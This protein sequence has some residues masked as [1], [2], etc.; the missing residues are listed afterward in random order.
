M[1]STRSTT[2]PSVIILYDIDETTDDSRSAPAMSRAR[3]LGYLQGLNTNTNRPSADSIGAYAATFGEL[4]D[5]FRYVA[6]DMQR[7]PVLF[8][9]NYLHPDRS[10]GMYGAAQKLCAL[11]RVQAAFPD[12]AVVLFDDRDE[13]VA[14]ARQ[15][16]FHAV[17]ITT[18]FVDVNDINQLAY[19]I[20]SSVGDEPALLVRRRA[21][22]DETRRSR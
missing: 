11:R 15:H 14:V 4:S 13:N 17:Q 5:G 9:S 1:P 3:A 6:A 22:P 10:C 18:G 2:V 20:N 19:S 16:R 7:Y 12:T 8:N 21:A